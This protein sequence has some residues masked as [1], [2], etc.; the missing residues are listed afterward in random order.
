V[1]SRTLLNGRGAE[2]H[3]PSPGLRGRL[4]RRQRAEVGYQKGAPQ[5]IIVATSLGKNT[6]KYG[7]GAKERQC[8]WLRVLRS[9]LVAY[10]V[11][12]LMFYALQRS[13]IYFPVCE[14]IQ[15][16]DA[17]LPRGQ[18]HTVSVAADDELPLHGWLVLADGCTAEDRDACDRELA[19]GRR[20]VLYFSGNGANRA[21]RMSEFGVLTGL[22][23]DVL[24]FDYR[25]YGD[26]LGSPSEKLIAAD[27]RTAWKYATQDRNVSPDRIILYGESLGGAVATGLAAD[28]CEADTPPAGLI[29]RSTFSSLVDA[30]AYHYPWLPVRL[31][32]V[33]RYP[34]IDR[35]SQ[36]TCPILQMHGTS[37]RIMPI[38]LGRRLFEAA[39]EHSS[40]GIA[41]EFVELSGAGH[42]DVTVVA[43]DQ[44]RAAIRHY[45]DRL[46]DREWLAGSDDL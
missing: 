31:A 46:D 8:R 25:G 4:S 12:V 20:L 17:G 21:Y 2:P 40:S 34:A 28:L 39:P 24:I 5:E 15:P 32:L 10:L 35:I 33:D 36:V 26:N 22:G 11:I 29:L 19:A 16:H 13:L 6:M 23:M 44:L 1:I 45:L 42:N 7:A 38:S 27:A 18:V 9:I 14:A 37:D 41:K 3:E 30:G 43:Q